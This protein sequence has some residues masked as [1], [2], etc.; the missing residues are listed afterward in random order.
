MNGSLVVLYLFLNALGIPPDIKEFNNRKAIQKA[1]Y[2]A[3]RLKLNGGEKLDLGYRFGW[4]TN[5]PYSPALS[6]DYYGLAESLRFE[7]TEH[8]EKIL[9]G[10]FLDRLTEANRF[11]KVPVSLEQKGV[12]LGDWL[13]LLASIDYLVTVGHIDQDNSE[14]IKQILTKEGKGHLLDHFPEAVRTLKEM[15]LWEA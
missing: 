1:I 14:E 2:L 6:D 12:K 3:Q 9:K 15:G 11:F 13:E 5:G 8:E 4:Y 10:P 7:E